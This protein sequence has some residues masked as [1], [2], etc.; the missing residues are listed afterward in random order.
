MKFPFGLQ[1]RCLDVKPSR[2]CLYREI[3]HSRVVRMELNVKQGYDPNPLACF[4][5]PGIKFV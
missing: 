3:V 5:V 1:S 4:E 2:M